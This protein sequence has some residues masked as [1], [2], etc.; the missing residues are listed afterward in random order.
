MIGIR[1]PFAL[2]VVHALTLPPLR[3]PCT[4]EYFLSE[5]Q[6]RARATA[7]QEAKQAKKVEE[8]AKQRQAAFVAPKVRVHSIDGQHPWP[9]GRKKKSVW[10]AGGG[11]LEAGIFS[12]FSILKLFTCCHA[13]MHLLGNDQCFTSSMHV[14]MELLTLWSIPM[15]ACSPSSCSLCC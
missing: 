11:D 10:T 13:C 14:C 2:D 1:Y 6:K 3:Y 7:A 5:E 15:P 4:G 8:R 9:R 12:Y